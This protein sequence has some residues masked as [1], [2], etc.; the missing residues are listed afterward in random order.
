MVRIMLN[1][2]SNKCLS[3]ALFLFA[4]TLL[5][6][7]IA[8]ESNVLYIDASTFTEKM[9]ETRGIAP[10]NGPSVIV[11][12]PLDGSEFS[13]EEKISVDI[14]FDPSSKGVP[15][16]METLNVK[17]KKG[18]FGKDITEDIREF[19]EGNKLHAPAVSMSGYTGSFKFVISIKDQTGALTKKLFEIDVKG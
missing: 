3:L 1:K 12:S 10:Q 18:W 15:P 8:A 13:Q 17:V 4:N 19:V 7:A 2:K 14:L 5:A 16:N 9:I 11:N 6:S